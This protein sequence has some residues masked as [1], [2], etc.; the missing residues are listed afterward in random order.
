MGTAIA[1]LV[2]KDK[3]LSLAGATE[4][5]GHP[6]MGK[7]LLSLG[8]ESEVKA[9]DDIEKIASNK[10]IIIDFT[11]PVSTINNIKAALAHKSPMIIGT[12]GFKEYELKIIED[13]AKTIPCVMAPSM[14]VGVNLLF[15]LVKDI[16]NTLGSD[17]DIEIV[18]THHR[19]KKDAPSGT[20]LKFAKNI[21]EAKG[22]DLKDIVLYGRE[23]MTGERK[24][25]T[26]GIHAVRAGDI[27]G[28]HQIIF[29]NLGERIELVHKAHSRD[30]Y[31]SGAIRAAKFL[32][33]NNKPGLFSMQEVLGLQKTD[34]R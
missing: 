19:F 2:I 18:E 9:S 17:Y 16:A 11:T 22:K 24:S 26:I 27:I 7:S 14:S 4:K 28:E 31:A 3:D 21:A 33:K 25:G 29:G 13:A 34:D 1:K 23:G 5:K 30:S 6:L 15:K 8:I 32:Y 20:A 12:T 10:T